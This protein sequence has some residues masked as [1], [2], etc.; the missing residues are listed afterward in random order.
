MNIVREFS[1]VNKWRIVCCSTFVMAFCSSSQ[2]AWK[3][4]F[5]SVLALNIFSPTFGQK[6]WRFND[7]FRSWCRTHATWRIPLHF[8]SGERI[9][10]MR[11][12]ELLERSLPK[13]MNAFYDFL[14]AIQSDGVCCIALVMITMTKKKR[15]NHQQRN[16]FL[17]LYVQSA[18]CSIQ[19]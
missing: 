8:G 14:N 9:K 17:P 12:S 4:L 16:E 19:S 7:R 3:C 5:S 15:K 1:G 11:N 6:L 10:L 13:H 2:T 18:V